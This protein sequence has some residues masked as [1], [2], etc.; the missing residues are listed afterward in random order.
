MRSRE[1]RTILPE[2]I[3]AGFALQQKIRAG[4]AA[5]ISR[6]RAARPVTRSL[7]IRLQFEVG[8]RFCLFQSGSNRQ[9]RL[10]LEST[11]EQT[12]VVSLNPQQL[13]AIRLINGC[14]IRDLS[15]RIGFD[16]RKRS[17]EHCVP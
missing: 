7:S 16:E 2:G 1:Q 10:E 12:E 3:L 6:S 11:S 13:I 5:P 17:C 4:G 14:F 8:R 9:C 15:T